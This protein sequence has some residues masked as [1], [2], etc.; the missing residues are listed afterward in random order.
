MGTSLTSARP[1]QIAMFLVGC[2]LG[3][4]SSCSCPDCGPPM[5]GSDDGGKTFKNY[6]NPCHVGC[7]RAVVYCEGPCPCMEH[8]LEPEQECPVPDCI[9]PDVYPTCVCA[10]CRQSSKNLQQ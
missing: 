4:C 6:K 2:L 5:C 3:P 7:E 9:C 8:E 10:D 1:I